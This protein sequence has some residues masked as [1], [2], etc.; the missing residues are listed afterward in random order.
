M[1]PIVLHHGFGGYPGY[2]IGPVKLNYFRGI[3]RAL[4]LGGRAVIVPRVHPTA[5]IRHRAQQLKQQ[6]VAALDQLR[7]PDD[8]VIVVAH[9]LG[10][11][12]ARYMVRRLGMA[13]RVAAV[14][15]VSTPHRGSPVADWCVRHLDRR[16]PLIRTLEWFGWDLG[17][18]RDLTTESCRRFNDRVP[19]AAGVRYFSVGAARPWHLVPAFAIPAHKVTTDAEGA[20]DALVSVASS[21]WGRPL[22]TWA[23]DHWHTINHR[24][25]VELRNPTGDI[26]PYYRRA[27]ERVEAA[28]GA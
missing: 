23:A 17:A 8:P 15:T 9:S 28:L 7:R 13:A 14:L 16:I 6:I 25:V 18:A 21:A 26:A 20:N 22:G 3:D 11:L 4:G 10:G 2:K 12:D 5:G 19:D 1:L 24:M 27:V